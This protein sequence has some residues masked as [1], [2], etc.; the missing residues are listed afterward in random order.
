MPVM[1]ILAIVIITIVIANSKP[2]RHKTLPALSEQ[3][4]RDRTRPLSEVHRI[5]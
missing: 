1:I 3:E 5:I 2:G 4:C